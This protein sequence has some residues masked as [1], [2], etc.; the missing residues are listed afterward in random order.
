MYAP[1]PSVIVLSP[2]EQNIL[3][4]RKVFV[5]TV[6]TSSV[7]T[8]GLPFYAKEHSIAVHRCKDV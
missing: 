3:S 5:I 7:G 1:E 8:R 6:V 2:E 4:K